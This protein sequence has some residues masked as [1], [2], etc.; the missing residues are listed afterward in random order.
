MK[1]RRRKRRRLEIEETDFAYH[2]IESSSILL[3]PEEAADPKYASGEK[4]HPA[5]EYAII[6]YSRIDPLISRIY[7]LNEIFGLLDAAEFPIRIGSNEF[8]RFE[9]LRLIVDL[10]HVRFTSIR[11]SSVLLAAAV[12][13]VN[14]NPR[15][16]RISSLEQIDGSERIV[17]ELRVL[18]SLGQKIRTARNL[19]FHRSE[20][21]LPLPDNFEQHIFVALA[22]ME[23]LNASQVDA[24]RPKVPMIRN[25]DGSWMSI[26]DIYNPTRREIVREYE[27]ETKK[28]VTALR[29]LF[30]FLDT[31]YLDKLDLKFGRR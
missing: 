13:E 19:N 12:L 6:V 1:N 3:A 23:T 8:S 22:K 24:S 15:K 27:T 4:L 5:K 30:R 25:E 17:R 14:Q 9:W 16:L 2:V 26:T 20:L 11:D 28:V 18:D 21:A 31:I 7:A 29:R 10:I